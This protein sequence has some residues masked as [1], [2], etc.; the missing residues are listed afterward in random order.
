MASRPASRDRRLLA[1]AAD[2]VLLLV[3]GFC[4]IAMG[5]GPPFWMVMIG[6]VAVGGFRGRRERWWG[7]AVAAAAGVAL[8][9]MLYGMGLM[10]IAKLSVI[11]FVIVAIARLAA[12]RRPA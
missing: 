3:A 7:L 9:G 6:L 1:A 10:L 4:A 8:L 11:T 2:G 12:R 5:L